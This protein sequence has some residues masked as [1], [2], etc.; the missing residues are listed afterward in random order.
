MKSL[1]NLVDVQGVTVCSVIHQPRKFIF[2][3]FDSLILLGVGGNLV[4]HGPVSKCE[5][6]FKMLKYDLPAGESIADWLIDISSGDLAPSTNDRVENGV[7]TS[8]SKD[9]NGV[10]GTS[11]NL[12]PMDGSTSSHHGEISAFGD[13]A[14][15]ND[16]FESATDKAKARREKLVRVISALYSSY[17]SKPNF[18]HFSFSMQ[19]G[20][21]TA[22]FPCS[23]RSR[24]W[25]Q[26]YQLPGW[27]L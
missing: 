14:M 26:I 19:T 6:Y 18:A 24:I 23:T 12:D 25:S 3:L 9:S 8:K 16:M 4:Y 27:E 2:E 11:S 21:R 20:G 7:N 15:A 17:S 13:D 1:K 10:D 5:K 22:W